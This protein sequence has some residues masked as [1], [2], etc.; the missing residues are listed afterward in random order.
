[1]PG[2]GAAD[3]INRKAAIMAITCTAPAMNSYEFDYSLTKRGETVQRLRKLG[4]TPSL[5]ATH[6]DAVDV[7]IRR[8][9]HGATILLN[10]MVTPPLMVTVAT[11]IH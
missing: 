8:T 6:L 1:M 10:P 2:F 7:S 9:G 3:L 4:F 11:P 5:I